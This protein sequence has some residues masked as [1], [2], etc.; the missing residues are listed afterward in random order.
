MNDELTTKLKDLYKVQKGMKEMKARKDELQ[1][2]VSELIVDLGMENQKIEVGGDAT[3]CYKN[4]RVTG[5]LSQGL[6]KERLKE[7]FSDSEEDAE[8]VEV[9]YRFILEGRKVTDKFQLDVVW[10]KG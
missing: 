4:K 7:Y 5:G 1:G 6:L 9:L 3:F 2:E 8:E 10:K